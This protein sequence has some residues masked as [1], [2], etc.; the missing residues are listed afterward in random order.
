ME[1]NDKIENQKKTNR[2]FYKCKKCLQV[3]K[4]KQGEGS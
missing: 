2:K 4:G 3:Q 1:W